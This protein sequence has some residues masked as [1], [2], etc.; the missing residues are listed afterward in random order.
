MLQYQ[1]HPHFQHLQFLQDFL[2][3]EVLQGL[4][5]Q[6]FRHFQDFQ[7]V[8]EKYLTLCQLFHFLDFQS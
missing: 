1:E 7:L 3:Q 4:S 2:L 5:L 6:G 8:Q